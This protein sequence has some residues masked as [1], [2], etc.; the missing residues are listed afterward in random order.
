M[1][2]RVAHPTER[3]FLGIEGG[4]TRTTA[5]LVD[6]EMRIVDRLESGPANLKLLSDVELTRHL[7]AIAA[8]VAAPDAVAIGLAGAWVETDRQRLHLAAAKAWPRVACYATNDL[9][10][11]LTAAED[12]S[13]DQ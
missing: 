7:R 13:N 6:E 10:V 9:E 3:L 8:A 4:G 1:S 2:S 11:A 12:G 5:L